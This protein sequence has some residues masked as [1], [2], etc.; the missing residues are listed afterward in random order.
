MAILRQQLPFLLARLGKIP[1]PRQPRR[2]RHKT[3]VLLLYGLLMFVFQFASRREVNCEL[4]RPMFEANLRLL[5]PELETLPHADT[6]YRLLRDIDLTHLEETHVALLERLIRGEKFRR[7]LIQNCYPL[8]L[9]GTQELGGDRLWDAQM[10]QRTHGQGDA[11]KTQY[12]VYV[13]E[14][15][16]TFHNG[17]VIPLLSEFLEHAQGDSERNKQDCELRAFHRLAERLKARFV[18]LPILLL[19][20]GLYANGPVMQRCRAYGWDFMI[21]LK[22][23][24][25]S[26]VWEEFH[27]LQPLQPN[28]RLGYTP[29]TAAVRPLPGSTRSNTSSA[30]TPTSL[31][32]YPSCSATS[33]GRSSRA[34]PS[35]LKHSRYAWL[36]SRPLSRLNVHDRCHLGARHRWGI[37]AG[38]LVEKHQGYP[39][40][41]RLC[42]HL[43]RHEG[44]P[45]ADAHGPPVQHPR[46]IRPAPQGILC[47]A[48]R[49][50]RHH[51]HPRH[52]QI[53]LARCAAHP[54]PDRAPIATTAAIASSLASLGSLRSLQCRPLRA[55]LPQSPSAP[56]PFEPKCAPDRPI[57]L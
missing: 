27:G 43:E 3:T 53:S 24:S 9:D 35:S 25:L 17:M 42:A 32:A 48:R 21:M 41:A 10:L 31:R 52:L 50:R 29:G 45:P 22:D 33:T 18:R 4:S 12:Y 37:E 20:D 57:C 46:P 5:F 2:N 36:S 38:F 13:L 16:L 8:S 15:S 14:A 6:L 49:A 19:L 34:A 39:Y 40:R 30:P 56:R 1:N 44:L 47:R 23:A 54:R 11:A 51:L 55:V 28:N 26:T 7:F